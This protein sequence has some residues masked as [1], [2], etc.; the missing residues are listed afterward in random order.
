MTEAD[1]EPE[2]NIKLAV[3]GYFISPAKAAALEGLV[4]KTPQ[5]E[6]A[7]WK[8]LGFYFAHMLCCPKH[9]DR[10]IKHIVWAIDSKQEILGGHVFLR[11]FLPV[12]EEK[13]AQVRAS[14]DR[15]LEANP[16]NLE[17]LQHMGEFLSFVRPQEARIHLE[18]VLEIEPGN[19][20]VKM[21]L[22][23][24]CASRNS[25]KIIDNTH[26]PITCFFQV[27]SAVP[28]LL[29]ETRACTTPHSEEAWTKFSTLINELVHQPMFLACAQHTKEVPGDGPAI[30]IC[31]SGLRQMYKSI[32]AKNPTGKELRDPELTELWKEAKILI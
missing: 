32:P 8:L 10:R 14:W 21:I 9:I 12:E 31:R 26:E 6:E 22:E 24:V 15:R 30:D 17:L 27:L 11:L 5:D 13:I 20:L 16:D 1:S 7:R 2:V 28:L 23:R 25:S 29:K 19:K 18:R 4:E 3:E